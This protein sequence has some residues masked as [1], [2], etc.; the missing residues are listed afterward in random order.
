MGEEA[1]CEEEERAG[2]KNTPRGPTGRTEFFGF[3]YLRVDAC[4][5]PGGAACEAFHQ[6]RCGGHGPQAHREGA[7]GGS[8]QGSS[9]WPQARGGPRQGVTCAQA[10][11]SASGRGDAT[12]MRPGDQVARCRTSLPGLSAR[13]GGPARPPPARP[14]PRAP[15]PA[16]APTAGGVVRTRRWHSPCGGLTREAAPGRR[17]RVEGPGEA[18]ERQRLAEGAARRALADMSGLL[19]R[20]AAPHSRRPARRRW[21]PDRVEDVGRGR[22]EAVAESTKIRSPGGTRPGGCRFRR[23]ARRGHAI[24][25]WSRRAR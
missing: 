12:R 9:R 6:A 10:W 5:V 11:A 24:A 17:A 8:S 23:H 7:A 22:A 20:R 19:M 13:M 2:G 25:H 16:S 18:R 14:P 1:R 4:V 3:L 21:H 15:T